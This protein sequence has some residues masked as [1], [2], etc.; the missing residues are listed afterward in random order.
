MRLANL[1]GTAI[2]R[3]AG[4]QAV[5]KQI[6]VAADHGEQVVEVVSD[7]AGHAAEG[8]HLLGLAKLAFEHFSLGFIAFQGVAHTV[9]GAG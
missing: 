4:L 1:L 3:V 5:E 9:K 8:F 6:A 7:A 2:E